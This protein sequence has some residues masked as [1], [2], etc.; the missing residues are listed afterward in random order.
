MYTSPDLLCN[1]KTFDETSYYS[2]H[3]WHDNKRNKKFDL[4]KCFNGI[5]VHNTVTLKSSLIEITVS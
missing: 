4:L 3:V 5:Q 1:F 2:F